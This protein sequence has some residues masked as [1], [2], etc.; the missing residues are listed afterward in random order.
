M[1]NRIQNDVS[2]IQK[3]W[4][5]YNQLSEDLGYRA[6]TVA[7]WRQRGCFPLEVIPDVIKIAKRRG[8]VSAI[9]PNDFRQQYRG[10]PCE[11]IA[12]RYLHE[13][14]DEAVKGVAA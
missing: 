13:L 3:L 2:R 5:S 14:R 8:F 4:A 9:A 7:I 10:E 6:G 1:S 12:F 11:L